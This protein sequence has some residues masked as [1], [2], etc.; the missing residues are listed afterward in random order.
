MFLG[1]GNAPHGAGS[2]IM[3]AILALALLVLSLPVAAARDVVFA[4]DEVKDSRVKLYQIQYGILPK[5]YT[6]TAPTVA[7]PSTTMTVSGMA[8]DQTYYAAV[9]ACT[10]PRVA[11][12]TDPVVPML[13]GPFSNEVK[14]NPTA[15]PAAPTGFRLSLVILLP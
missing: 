13:C 6:M 8:D 2:L 3:R 1:G 5:V 7:Q 4:W 15:A 11:T 14:V 9:R 12:A 10:E